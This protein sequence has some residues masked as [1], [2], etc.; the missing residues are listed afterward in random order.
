MSIDYLAGRRERGPVPTFERSSCA[1]LDPLSVLR[2]SRRAQGLED[3]LGPVRDSELGV[4]VGKLAGNAQGATQ[5]WRRQ[6][7][8]VV[9]P[10]KNY[11]ILP[12][13][14]TDGPWKH[15]GR[16]GRSTGGGPP[17]APG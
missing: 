4:E 1:G 16:T 2:R 7:L 5:L 6:G 9:S 11:A 10:D 13:R 15:A 14:R 3:G 8:Q 12:F 17:G